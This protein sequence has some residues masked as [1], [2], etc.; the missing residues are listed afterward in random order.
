MKRES[1]RGQGRR[2]DINSYH[3][4]STEIKSTQERAIGIPKEINRYQ[5][6]SSEVIQP[7]RD[8]K[9]DQQISREIK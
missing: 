6:R 7:V 1:R 5:E 3:E 8:I 4:R 2:R 9:R